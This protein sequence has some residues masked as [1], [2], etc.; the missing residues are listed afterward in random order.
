MGDYHRARWKALSNLHESGKVYAADLGTADHLY[1]WNNTPEGYVN[2]I[3]FSNKPVRKWDTFNRIQNFIKTVKS[4]NIKVVCIP[5]Y[6]RIEYLIFLIL[7]KRLG[8]H[9]ILFAESWYGSNIIFNNLKSAFLNIFCDKYLV[10]GIRAYNHFNKNLNI[11]NQRIKTCYSVIDNDHFCSKD[12]QYYK[13]PVLLCVA[14]FSK[15]KNLKMLIKAFDKSELSKSFLLKLI[16]GGSQQPE[17]EA[18]AVGIN[19]E[20]KNWMAYEKLPEVYQTASLFIL[21]STFEPWGL[22]VNEAMAAGLPVIVSNQ[23]GCAP[24]LVD[25]ENGFLFDAKDE[26][27]LVNVFNKIST[28]SFEQLHAMGEKSLSKI[29]KYSPRSWADQLFEFIKNEKDYKFS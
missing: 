24:D 8:L 17:L 21:P 18:L 20:L 16:G 12:N 19:V 6:G 22:V 26:T 2:Y 11:P 9:V 28:M 4:Y 1:Q 5:G 15:E 13:M 29:R 10:S 25:T 23:C 3:S 14:R 7:S 27:T